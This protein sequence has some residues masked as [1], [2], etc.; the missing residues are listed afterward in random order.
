MA[1]E[2]YDQLHSIVVRGF[3]ES[4]LASSGG[5]EHWSGKTCDEIQHKQTSGEVPPFVV[6]K[7]LYFRGGSAL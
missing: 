1:V 6:T 4:M 5:G 3:G 7:Q 2:Y